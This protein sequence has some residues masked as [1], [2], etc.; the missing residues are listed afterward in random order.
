MPQDIM[1]SSDTEGIETDKLQAA[2]IGTGAISQRLHIPAYLDSDY[3]DLVAVCDVEEKKATAVADSYGIE[4]TYTDYEAMLDSGEVDAVSVCLP[5][6]LHK[7]VVCG[8][9]ERDIHVLCEK[10]ICTSLSEAD[11][12]IEAA[13]ASQAQLMIDQT[14]RFNPVYEKT[15]DLLEKGVVGDVLS[16][17][18][19]FSHPGPEG[20]SPRSAWFTDADASGG[21]ALIDIGI[22]NAD[23]IN[24]LFDDVASL[25]GYSDTLSMDTEVE[26]TAVA[27]LRFN[28][29]ALGTFE[30]AWRTD[31]ESIEMQIVGEEGVI[32][33]DKVEPSIRLELG[34][35]CGSVDVP[36]PEQSKHGGPIQ[37][38]IES[39]RSGSEP[40]VTGRDG[41]QALEI[42]LAVYQSSESSE[43][44][45][46]P[47]ET[48]AQE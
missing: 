19:R 31:P 34:N 30:T 1:I 47:L 2:V 33:V 18:S 38:F 17:R 15:N 23:L 36:V 10:P 42:V 25:S 11:A 21:G 26:D 28:D 5:N 16:V 7:D 29:G 27:A 45:T 20:W 48:E 14:E 32:Y 46:L 3:A 43:R 13:D 41:K 39:A 8:A 9:L 37:H 4:S 24:Y 6:H 12:M 44:V 40:T 35:D 22:H